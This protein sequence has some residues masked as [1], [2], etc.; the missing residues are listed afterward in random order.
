MAA[1]WWS[2]A[3]RL[4][5]VIPTERRA[6]LAR[7]ISAIETELGTGPLQIAG[8]TNVLLAAR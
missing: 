5:Q 7:A 8:A 2:M 1:G 4:D 6:I 3:I